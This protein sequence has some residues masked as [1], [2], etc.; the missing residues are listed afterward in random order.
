MR[1]P[2]CDI[3]FRSGHSLS[4]WMEVTETIS[5]HLAAAD[6]RSIFQS[7][8]RRKMS[9]FQS[10]VYDVKAVPIEKVRANDYNPNAVA[11]PEMELLEISIWEDGYTQPVV[12]Y[13]DA[14]EDIYIVVDG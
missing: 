6:D 5:A 10:P 9:Q 11:P 2:S 3:R 4:W 13:H 1:D 14:A 12:T 8:G 7:S